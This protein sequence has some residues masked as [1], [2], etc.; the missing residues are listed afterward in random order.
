MNEIAKSSN[1]EL[2]TE[3]FYN[4][5]SS[6]LE[7]A[8]NH[9]YRAVNSAMVSAYWEIGRLIVKKQ[10]GEDHAAYGEGLIK[11]LSRRLTADFGRGFDASNLRNM[12]QFYLGFQN[13][14]ALRHELSWTHYRSLS[15][16][17][18]E[19]AR[20]WYMN[21]CANEGWAFINSPRHRANGHVCAHV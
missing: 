6:V 19:D 8:R 17:T 1:S 2:L 15:R 11:E 4:S 7:Q 13:C 14:D 16:V 12:R 21:E 9:A 18:D 5:V 3:E 10:G 20:T